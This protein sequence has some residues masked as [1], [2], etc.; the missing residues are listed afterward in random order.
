MAIT[1]ISVKEKKGTFEKDGK[2]IDYHNFEIYGLNP[3]STNEQVV[4]GGE[5]KTFKV[6]ANTFVEVLKRNFDALNDSS[7]TKVQD[8]IGLYISPVF[9]EWGAKGGLDD[10]TLAVP[11]STSGKKKS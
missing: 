6:K 5:V 7:I 2:S 8:I 1:I 11:K 9:G 3:F 4:A 10:F